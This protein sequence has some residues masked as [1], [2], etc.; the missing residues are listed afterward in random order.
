[1][2]EGPLAVGWGII[3]YRVVPDAPRLNHE[4]I[5]PMTAQLRRRS[6]VEIP[7]GG[8]ARRPNGR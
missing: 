4:L 3:D 1:M 8:S 7:A 5:D 6:G 2:A